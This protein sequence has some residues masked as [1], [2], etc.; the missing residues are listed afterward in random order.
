MARLLAAMS[1]GV[2]SSVAAALACEAG[3]DVTGVTLRLWDNPTDAGCCSVAEI[4]DARAVADRLGIDHRVWS[5][6]EDFEDQVVAPYVAAHA[7]G[8]TPNPCI[9]CNRHL[10][11]GLLLDRALA[12]GF[13]GLVTGHHARRI[14]ASAVTNA[15]AMG[16]APGADAPPSDAPQSGALSDA[17]QHRLLRGCDPDKDQSYVLYVLDQAR[18]GRCHFP[19]GSMTK[20]QVRMQAQARGLP[21]AAKADSQDACFVITS[22]GRR[23]LLGGRIE[24]H[25]ATVVDTWG[26]PVGRVEAVELITVGQ[27]R[28]LGLGSG[29]P[30]V[31]AGPTIASAPMADCR[32]RSL[33]PS[34]GQPG[35]GSEEPGKAAPASRGGSSIRYA[36]HVDPVGATVVVGSA[37]DLMVDRVDL[38]AMAWITGSPPADGTLV[39]AQCSAHG[40]AHPARLHI[41]G[42]ARKASGDHQVVFEQPRRRV[43]PGQSVV[44]YDV[45]SNTEVLG[46]GIVK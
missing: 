9:D 42:S 6:T 4:D 18:L 13:D 34:G 29:P 28:G 23:A 16:L 17:P 25:P 41:G 10:K 40:P 35:A 7:A 44:L 31:G 45:A 43:A 46:G 21:T 38:A 33:G 27:R 37:A 5:Y 11:F 32:T 19:V 3:H 39:L 24:L 15:A 36:L 2:D 14:C 20:A 1:G 22:G 12:L 8:L 30:G 26:R